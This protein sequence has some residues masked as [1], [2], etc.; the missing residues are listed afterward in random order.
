M[1]PSLSPTFVGSAEWSRLS[2]AAQGV[3]Q[4]LLELA[5]MRDGQWCVDG[6]PKELSDWFGR[7]LSIAPARIL[8]VLRELDE[9][10]YLR[11]GRR[12]FTSRFV[13]AAP[14]T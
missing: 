4:G 9:A 8:V 12:G 3:L 13:L 10:G 5:I 6:T 14:L 7:E 11:K 1:Q 2:T